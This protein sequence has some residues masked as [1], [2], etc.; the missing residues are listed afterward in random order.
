MPRYSDEGVF[1][2]VAKTHFTF[3]C[4]FAIERSHT[5][6]NKPHAP[7]ICFQN[8]DTEGAETTK[9]GVLAVIYGESIWQDMQAIHAIANV[10]NLNSKIDE[11]EDEMQA[12]GRVDHIYNE[13]AKWPEWAAKLKKDDGIPVAEVLEA[14]KSQMVWDTL[15]KTIGCL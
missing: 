15:D 6:F 10:G 9:D 7:K 8:T 13:M 5:L 14:L 3:A 12:F 2:A 11:A 4:K 1:V